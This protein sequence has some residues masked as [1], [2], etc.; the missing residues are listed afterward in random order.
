MSIERIRIKFLLDN[1]GDKRTIM[2]LWGT[3]VP[4]EG[5]IV[6]FA[7][8]RSYRPTGGDGPASDFENRYVVSSVEWTFGF[9]DGDLD[10]PF[11]T[12]H[13]VVCETEE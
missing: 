12:A 9:I 3:V 7:F 13:V 8:E 4:S 11:Q 5:E 1:G 2:G 10:R 6:R